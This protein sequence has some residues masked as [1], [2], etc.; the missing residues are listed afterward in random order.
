[1][2]AHRSITW[3][4]RAPGP[5]PARRTSVQNSLTFSSTILQCLSTAFTRP[6]SFLLFLQLMRTCRRGGGGVG[7]Q[8][9]GGHQG[10]AGP[11]AAC[12]QLPGLLP[13]AQAASLGSPRACEL[14]LTLVVSTD[15]GPVRNSSSSFFSSSS[16]VGLGA[17][18]AMA[19]GD[20]A[21]LVWGGG[22]AAVN[23]S[24]TCLEWQERHRWQLE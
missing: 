24:L 17:C 19:A 5:P 18:V 7:R 9:I 11:T 22:C 10:H 14:V 3:Q 16:T 13:S 6:S 8:G 1:M 20:R 2:Q 12:R 23:G 15:S 4:G 21:V